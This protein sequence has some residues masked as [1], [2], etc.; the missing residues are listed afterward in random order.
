MSREVD[1]REF[2]INR[3]TPGRIAAA[4]AAAAGVSDRLPGARRIRIIGFDAAT[5][6]PAVIAL[7]GG[8][9]ESGEYI[10]RALEHV[11]AIAP[12][13]A[14]TAQ[15][16]EYVPDPLVQ[17]T[18]SGARS[19]NLQQRYT[20]IPVFHA[21]VQVRFGPD[22]TL[23]DTAG[24]TVTVPADVA[25]RPRLSVQQAVLAA[26]RH[27][28]EPTPDELDHKDQFGEP[29][30][31]PRVDISGFEPKIRAAFPESPERSTV[32]EQGPFGAEIKAS[33]IWFYL[34]DQL[35]LSWAVLLTM[36][37]YQGQYYTIVNAETGEILYA[38]QTVLSVVAQGD[39]Y[40]VDPGHGRQMTRFPRPWGD[41]GLR[42]PEIGQDNWRWCHKCQGL[43]FG[44]NPGPVCPAGGAHENAGSG[45]YVLVQNTP[46]YPGQ[47]NWRWCHKCQGLFFGG[48]PG[49]ICPA[50]G[51]HDNAGSGDYA[52]QNNAPLAPGQHD[53]RWCHKCQGLYFAG[54]PGAVCP[55]G[56]SHENVGSGDYSLLSV[57]SGLPGPAPDEWVTSSQ[58]DGNSTFAHLGA[59]G[60]A[61]SGSVAGGVTTFDPADALGDDQKVLNI[62]YYCCYMHDFAYLLGF[63][64]ADGNFQVDDHGRGGTGGDRVDARSF[65]GAVSG[66]AN[67]SKSVEGTSPIMQMGLVTSTGRHTAFD[68]TVVFHEFTHGISGRLVGGPMDSTSLDSPQSAGMGEGWSDYIACTINDVV[69]V[70]NWVLNNTTGVRMFPYDSSF[71]DGFGALGT[72]RY[73]GEVHN[74]GEIWAATLMEMNRRT[75]KYLA[76]QLVIDALKL[77]PAQPSFLDARDA[78]LL[79][80]DHML[81]AGRIRVNQR[82]GA[83]QGI[84][85]AFARFGMG[86]RAASLGAAIAGI[87]ADTSVGQDNWRWC[88]KCQGLYFGGNPGPV[89][90]AG[91]AHENIGSGNYELVQNRIGAPGQDDWRWCHKCQGLYF[92][93]NPG[94]ICPAGGPH[95]NVGSGNYFLIQNA[96]GSPAQND[97]RWCHKCQ[98]L[99]FAGNPG[100]V[101]PAGGAHE[102]VG[103]GDYSL[104]SH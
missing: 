63:R 64:E 8:A 3:A 32:L 59:A 71:P 45:D 67:M 47:S 16:P 6:N 95:E 42:F 87:V 21:A 17:E 53:W 28:A 70:G 10:R 88:H 46:A 65:P 19:V 31:P 39:V 34:T 9:P 86:P 77:T 23:G 66:T 99:Y 62:F 89:C 51:A 94:P 33:L 69:V 84:W 90:P 11:Q 52:L 91:G 68:S 41:Y 98:G 102:N 37:D 79:A 26:A 72:G 57:A 14:P 97:W 82:D 4:E 75:D 92:G 85:S 2:T 49:S 24:T 25:V 96:W 50:G 56:G 5:G 35:V 15:A 40:R 29:L 101:C 27:V 12:A 13:L 30:T 93:G 48:N 7:D 103:S 60:A 81:A 20:G 22:G 18:S 54:N 58:T 38:H 80:L 78:I 74:T 44:G 43:F 61:A 55:A 76:V 104:L 1:L 83:W 100:P 73:T 36:P